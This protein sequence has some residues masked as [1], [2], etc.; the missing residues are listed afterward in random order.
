[1]AN[2]ARRRIDGA[3]R[4]AWQPRG[5]RV[6]ARSVMVAYRRILVPVDFSA[7]SDAAIE[8]ALFLRKHLDA[9]VELLHVWETPVYTGVDSL[10]L[11]EDPSGKKTSLTEFVRVQAEHA[12]QE[13]LDSLAKKGER[14][15]SGRVVPGDPAN[16]IV[17]ASGDY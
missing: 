17:G 7:C 14:G 15:L 13:Q 16:E 11:I 10:L 8:H 6:A 5:T 4:T 1:H 2:A 9:Q 12:M 3:C